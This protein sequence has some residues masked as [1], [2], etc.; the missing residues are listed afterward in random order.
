MDLFVGLPAIRISLAADTLRLF[1]WRFR[2]GFS[3]FLLVAGV[4]LSGP[5]TKAWIQPDLPFGPQVLFRSGFQFMAVLITALVATLAFGWTTFRDEARRTVQG[6]DADDLGWIL[7]PLVY[8]ATIA[9]LHAIEKTAGGE[10]AEIRFAATTVL[11]LA[12]ILSWSLTAMPFSFWLRFAHRGAKMLI[13][14]GV[15]GAITYAVGHHY[16]LHSTAFLELHRPTLWTVYFLLRL[17][18]KS[19]TYDPAHYLIGTRNFAVSVRSACSGVEGIALFLIFFAIYLWVC[20]RE[21]R[22]PHVLVLFPL[23]AAALWL[24]NA[25]RIVLLILIGGWSSDIAI[26][27]F[28]SVAGWLFFNAVTLMLVLVSRRSSIFVNGPG[29]DALSSGSNPAAPYLAPLMAIIVATMIARIFFYGFDTLYP[30]RVIAGA[31]AVWFYRRTVAFSGWSVSWPAVAL[32]ALVFV[33]WLAL[34]PRGN[35]AVVDVSFRAAID[36]LPAIAAAGWL[37]F[38]VG[39][40]LLLAPVAEEFAFRGYVLRKL[41]S[42][43]FES[44]SLR[45]FT[46]LSFLGSSAIFG[47]MHSQ[48]LAGTVAG[49]IFALAAYRRGL[50]SDAVIS[51]ATANGLLSA[52]VLITGHWSLWT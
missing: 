43:D 52:Y 8:L 15:V 38:R 48:W 16:A 23:G 45:R 44:V 20:R 49:M 11:M 27:G 25:V 22:F 10:G 9:A 28:H 2:W 1:R 3:G 34:Q 31:A 6:A 40:A 17:T 21:F 36:G 13:G 41:I 30:L 37:L 51:H 4:L 35:V 32:G 33:S 29:A 26:N 24:L 5:S 39:G 14:G 50:L 18:G 12:A 7:W 42:A 46:W 47:A 19:V